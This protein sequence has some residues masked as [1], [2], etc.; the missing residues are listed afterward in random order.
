MSVEEKKIWLREQVFDKLQA[1]M[2]VLGPVLGKGYLNGKLQ[3]NRGVVTAKGRDEPKVGEIYAMWQHPSHDVGNLIK[4]IEFPSSYK[5]LS[6][7]VLKGC[8]EF[9]ER[10]KK[11]A[12]QRNNKEPIHIDHFRSYWLQ[13][14]QN[15]AGDPDPLTQPQVRLDEKEVARVYK[16]YVKAFKDDDLT[17]YEFFIDEYLRGKKK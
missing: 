15:K 13:T 10:H 4:N 9:P 2:D 11:S 6:I 14:L 7:N 5:E 8:L 3:L 12:K 17:G 16:R 1:K